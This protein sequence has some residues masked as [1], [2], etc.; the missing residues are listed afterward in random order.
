MEARGLIVL[1]AGGT[2]GH[3]F[4][5]RAL[6]E[7]LRARG[8]RL[9]LI[10]DR[11]GEAFGETLSDVE[12]YLISAASPGGGV[13]GK[14]R[15]L[16]RLATGLLQAR[17]LLRRLKPDAVVGFGG[18]ASVP[19]MLAA[20]LARLPTI[21]HEQNAVLGRANRLLAPRVTRIATSFARVDAL[22]PGDAARAVLTGNPVRA[23]I[24]AIGERPYPEL[25]AKSGVLSLLVFGGSQGA[26]VLSDVVP[27]AAARLCATTRKRLSVT[28]QCR[29]ED[30]ER[31]RAAYRN[32][33]IEAT[34]APFFEDLPERLAA[35]HLVIGRA[36]ASTVAELAAAGRPALL[37]PYPFAADDHQRANARAVD[38][39]GGGWLMPEPGFTAQ[40]LAA[41]LESLL[42][43]PAALG[44]AAAKAR[45]AARP[46][47]AA[48]LADLTETVAARRLSGAGAPGGAA[49]REAA[50]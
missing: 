21:I 31:V 36:G 48:A 47:A 46:D 50:A 39:A 41:R 19:T 10:T 20:A 33:G 5:A 18:Y 27:A 30:L 9:A 34:L 44:E 8:W 42:G 15:A 13:G 16:A 11:R 14:L 43:R 25:A 35:A 7:A 1:A 24:A 29:A 37:V 6:A 22:R 40:A 49:R 32:A 28:Q 4:P 23:A 17:A 38:E 12:T 26:R 3:V 2:G 45:L